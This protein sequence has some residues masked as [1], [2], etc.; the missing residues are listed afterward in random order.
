[1][2]VQMRRAVATLMAPAATL[3]ARLRPGLRVLMYHRVD[4]LP[5]YDQ[6]TVAPERFAD[7]M[8]W[9]A[10]H[11]RLLS[12][13]AAVDELAGGGGVRPGVVVTF[14]DGY[15]DNLVHAL[16]V[17]RQHGIPATI[18]VTAEFCDQTLRHPRYPDPP[19]RLHLD[20]D[21]VR[22]LARDPLVTIGSHSLTHPHL[23]RLDEQRARAEI[24]ESRAR[25]AAEIGRPVELFCYPSGD[26][27]PREVGMVR[28][29]GYR[30]AVSVAPGANRP[31][32]PLFELRR[33]E[34]TDRDEPRDLRAKLDGAYDLPHAWLHRRRRRQLEAAARATGAAR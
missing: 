15:R 23:S 14:D 22:A 25:I 3:H 18:F 32:A 7:Q 6:L 29:A 33:T 34:A 31:G 4:R 13:P 27:G 20:W 16:P 21:E 8:A 24:G 30:A 28:A 12:L 11:A 2:T 17:L 9:L 10:R 1:M 19:A 5:A 26:F